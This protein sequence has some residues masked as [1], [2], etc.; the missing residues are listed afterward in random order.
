MYW[1]E[2]G[3]LRITAFTVLAVA[4]GLVSVSAQSRVKFSSSSTN[5]TSKFLVPAQDLEQ[6]I[7]RIENAA[8]RM[9]SADSVPDLPLGAPSSEGVTVIRNKKLEEWLDQQKNWIFD[10]QPADK[11]MLEAGKEETDS[12]FDGSNGKSK[13]TV[14]KYFENLQKERENAEKNLKLNARD[15]NPYFD[16]L[17][18]KNELSNVAKESGRLNMGLIEKSSRTP[19]N[20]WDALKSSSMSNVKLGSIPEAQEPI[21]TSLTGEGLTAREER[22]RQ[23]R[24][25][26]DREYL[27]LFRADKSL[28]GVPSG[29]NDP[30]NQMVDTSRS[31]VQPVTAP[32]LDE[33]GGSVKSQGNGFFGQ[34]ANAAMP[35]PS[36]LDEVLSVKAFG[37]SSFSSPAFNMSAPVIIQPK[38]AVLEMPRRKF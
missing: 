13:K 14:E 7:Q 1:K 29:P 33:I 19:Q 28:V 36:S 3:R 4:A 6:Q 35:R 9:K 18:N 8:G 5:A 25:Q 31:S 17:E 21:S 30:I 22:I 24:L 37:A 32:T 11:K 23:E 12:F 38:P 10:N 27:Q 34:N 20:G 2:H 16:S 15:I 26:A